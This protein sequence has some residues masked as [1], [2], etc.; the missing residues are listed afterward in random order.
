MEEKLP[1]RLESRPLFRKQEPLR[2]RSNMLPASSVLKTRT[3]ATVT[4]DRSDSYKVPLPPGVPPVSPPFL[5]TDTVDNTL[6]PEDP[7]SRKCDLSHDKLADEPQRNAFP[8][9]CRRHTICVSQQRA[10]DIFKES[11]RRS[12]FTPAKG[13]VSR[14]ER[15]SCTFIMPGAG[16]NLQL[17]SG[18][19]SACVHAI[20]RV[21]SSLVQF[22]DIRSTWFHGS[23]FTGSSFTTGACAGR[24]LVLLPKAQWHRDEDHTN[25]ETCEENP[26][27]PKSIH[28]C[29]CTNHEHHKTK[30]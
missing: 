12:F 27:Q 19:K 7:N 8:V 26:T 16:K 1:N 13:Q 18:V 25:C 11:E 6:P 14:E 4:R 10:R 23:Q 5:D 30:A 15:H 24:S 9:R 28:A 22:T 3:V 17:T 2:D 20:L 29:M 21:H